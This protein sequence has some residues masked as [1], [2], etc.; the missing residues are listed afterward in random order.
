MQKY[1]SLIALC[2]FLCITYNSYAKNIE[3]IIFQCQLSNQ[4]TITIHYTNIKDT[5][6]YIYRHTQNGI[7][8]I[9]IKQNRIKMLENSKQHF[10]DFRGN[11]VNMFFP[12]GKYGY[13]VF[14]AFKV[15]QYND[16]DMIFYDGV[17]I[18]KG[19]NKNFKT[20]KC[21]K[22]QKPLSDEHFNN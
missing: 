1:L 18:S 3:K 17:Y 13:N 6:Y 5:E 16:D 8:R 22:V 9:E 15:P 19:Q 14:S 2:F 21:H 20:I 10:L 7:K 12:N 4:S 11:G